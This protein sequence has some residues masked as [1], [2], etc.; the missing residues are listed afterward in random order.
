MTKSEHVQCPPHRAV[1]VAPILP[2][3][4]HSGPLPSAVCQKSM[5]SPPALQ[6]PCIVL[7]W[8]YSAHY[9]KEPFVDVIKVAIPLLPCK[10]PF[11]DVIKVAIK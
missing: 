2:W 3:C 4:R 7:Q 8:V 9:C 5:H 11:V 10:E 1:F 6:A